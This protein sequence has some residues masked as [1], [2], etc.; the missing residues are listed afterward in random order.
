MCEAGTS[1]GHH[2]ENELNLC[3]PIIPLNGQ[4]LAFSMGKQS[5]GRGG[6]SVRDP[7]T[8]QSVP[9]TATCWQIN[10]TQCCSSV[11]HRRQNVYYLY[12]SE[13]I[14]CYLLKSHL[15]HHH[16]AKV[17]EETPHP[18]PTRHIPDMV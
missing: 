6:P 7:R 2:G 4:D 18:S 8:V 11:H 5:C 14:W 16:G 10:H 17:L 12:K 3:V 13:I 15:P 1:R 9:G